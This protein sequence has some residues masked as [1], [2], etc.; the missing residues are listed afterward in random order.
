MSF[1]E[2]WML[3]G[4]DGGRDREFKTSLRRGLI[5]LGKKASAQHEELSVGWQDMMPMILRGENP[6]NLDMNDIYAPKMLAWT[7]DPVKRRQLALNLY[8]AGIDT[9]RYLNARKS[10]N[11][12]V[13]RGG[14]GVRKADTSRFRRLLHLARVARSVPA[15]E[16]IDP[17]SL[18]RLHPVYNPHVRD[19]MT[20]KFRRYGWTGPVLSQTKEHY[21]HPGATVN[22]IRGGG[23]HRRSAAIKANIYVPYRHYRQD[24]ESRILQGWGELTTNRPPAEIRNRPDVGFESADTY[25]IDS[26][27]DRLSGIIPAE[28]PPRIVHVSPKRKIRKADTSRFRRLLRF[29]RAAR[30]VRAHERVDAHTFPAIH[31]AHSDW[32]VDRITEQFK[33]YGW[34]GP[35]MGQS[36][37]NEGAPDEY[38]VLALGGGTHRRVAATRAGIQIP[39][40]WRQDDSEQRL[41]DEWDS[42]AGGLKLPG[43]LD[44]KHGRFNHPNRTARILDSALYRVEPHIPSGRIRRVTHVPPPDKMRKSDTSRFRRLLH[45]ARVARSIPADELI[46]PA[47]VDVHQPHSDLRINQLFSQFSRHGWRGPVMRQIPGDLG[48]GKVFIYGGGSHRTKA[49][50]MAGIKVPIRGYRDDGGNELL[51]AWSNLTRG[52]AVGR[53]KFL[54]ARYIDRMLTRTLPH[55]SPDRPSRVVHV[56]P[57]GR[58]TR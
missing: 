32:H 56:S 17:R 10:P 1:R 34:R 43:G 6:S 57:P 47:R 40:R 31:D 58:R 27:L 28:R 51:T 38:Q 7:K 21:Y 14:K 20:K 8:N 41:L 29:A 2:F 44:P 11:L 25:E 12:R 13:I 35:V 33:K 42:I 50:S 54:P 3:P 9:A 15:D 19:L 24:P 22:Q 4:S 16:L 26:V 49:A 52:K 36:T 45:L 5:D 46:D 48:D 55:L 53:L 18:P 39:F 37:N 30:A 23:T